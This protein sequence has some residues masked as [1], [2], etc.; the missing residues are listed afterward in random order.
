MTEKSP[1]TD[2][3]DASRKILNA[4]A[5]TVADLEAALG[6]VQRVLA[7]GDAEIEDMARRRKT[8]AVADASV[9]EIKKALDHHDAMERVL[10]DRNEIA[11]AVAGKIEERIAA[12]REAERLAQEIA[13][14]KE[15][16]ARRGEASA[17][18]LDYL[19][20]FGR[21][22][23][24]VLREHLTLEV[25][26]QRFNKALPKGA[27]T[28]ASVEADRRVSIQPPKVLRERR[29]VAF[30]IN[31]Q[32]VAEEG[33]V[34]AAY[35]RA[36]G[37]WQLSLPSQCV[38]GRAEIYGCDRVQ[39]VE[40]EMEEE[41]PPFRKDSW[42]SFLRIPSFMEGEPDWWA[43]M[44][45]DLPHLLS[46]LDNLES[47]EP[48]RRRTRITTSLILDAAAAAAPAPPAMAAE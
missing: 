33:R 45:S 12:D 22:G 26:I 16:E 38:A 7:E 31:G 41:I 21:E 18:V 27:P 14:R 15:L 42:V 29:F 30:A 4:A 44:D 23:R 11:A 9:A 24:E 28:I 25:E 34:T 2:P 3:I 32:V 8:I 5:S 19:T 40:R 17:R 48:H 13:K 10:K 39:C 43:T 20:R 35:L 46:H 36:D 1:N 6:A 37:K 47:V